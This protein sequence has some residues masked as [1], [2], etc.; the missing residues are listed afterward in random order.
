MYALK[1]NTLFDFV[2][3]STDIEWPEDDEA[4]SSEAVGAIEALLTMEPKDRP[5]AGNVRQMSLF[6]NVD[7]ED[8]LNQEPPFIPTPDDLHDT[9][10]FQG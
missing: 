1:K 8:L 9:G 7:W 6:R 10:Y 2:I 5:A 4:L 3:H